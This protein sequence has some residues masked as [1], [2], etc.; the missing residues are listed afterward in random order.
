MSYYVG[1][2]GLRCDVCRAAAVTHTRRFPHT[3][4]CEYCWGLH[5][6]NRY[7]L[8]LTLLVTGGI[9]GGALWVL[10]SLPPTFD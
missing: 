3:D 10:Y 6:A 1:K 5:R 4:Y 9:L 2:D 7:N 8:W